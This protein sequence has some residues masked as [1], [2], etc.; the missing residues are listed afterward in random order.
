MEQLRAEFRQ[1]GELLRD[2]DLHVVAR[3]SFVIRHA[4]HVDLGHGVHVDQVHVV[5][6]GP[7][8]VGRALLVMLCRAR[9]LAEC[10]DSLDDELGL[11]SQA[12]VL[13]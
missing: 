9:L 10:L 1:P 12:E 2:R 3:D 4:L 11:R 6:A 8:A 5:R 13:G 7:R